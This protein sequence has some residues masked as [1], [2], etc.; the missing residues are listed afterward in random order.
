MEQVLLVI[1]LS[2]L[3]GNEADKKIAK[4]IVS[5]LDNKNKLIPVC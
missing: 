5:Y 1:Y 3:S 4:E 2:E